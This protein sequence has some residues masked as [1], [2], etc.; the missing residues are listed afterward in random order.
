MG[1]FKDQIQT[2]NQAIRD[3]DHRLDNLERGEVR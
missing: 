1:N 3:N 2:Q